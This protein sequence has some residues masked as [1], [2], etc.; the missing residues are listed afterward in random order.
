MASGGRFLPA[1]GQRPCRWQGRLCQC[2]D[3][4]RECISRGAFFHKR[5]AVRR[6]RPLCGAP[7][8]G[9]RQPCCTEGNRLALVC[10][11]KQAATNS[12]M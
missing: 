8:N 5:E 3:A 2:F 9:E 11:R 1:G 10:G 12:S 4:P 6:F 7:M